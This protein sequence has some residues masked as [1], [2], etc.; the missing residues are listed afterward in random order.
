MQFH[1]LLVVIILFIEFLPFV[2]AVVAVVVTNYSYQKD[3]LFG[4]WTTKKQM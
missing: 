3:K 4:V 1:F 2:A